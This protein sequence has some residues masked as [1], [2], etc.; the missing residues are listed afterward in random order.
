MKGAIALVLLLAACSDGG[1][2]PAPPTPTP[3][4]TPTPA[5]A[6][7]PAPV[8]PPPVGKTT[9]TVDGHSFVAELRPETG[10]FMASEPIFGDFVLTQPDDPKL[11]VQVAW[12]GEN[13]LGRPENINVTFVGPSGPLPVPDAGPAFG[14]QS[15][16]VTLGERDSVQRLYLSTWYS[17]ITPGAYTIKLAT[18][19]KAGIGKVMKDVDVAVEVPVEVVADD[20][21][22]L[23]A[24]I[25][26]QGAVVRGTDFDKAREALQ[27][28]RRIRDARVIDPLVAATKLPDYT[29]RYEALDCLE[30]WDDDRALAAIIAVGKTVA[31][32]LPAEGYTT[33]ALR[34]ES[35]AQL[36]VAAVGSLG[37]SKRPAAL[38]AVIAMKDDP[39]A[40]VRLEVLQRVAQLPD[41][42][43]LALLEGFAK[44]KSDPVRNEAK[45]Y[46]KERGHASP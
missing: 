2:R 14:G 17:A 31:A 42:T 46:L 1:K 40:D 33:A 6:P 16:S 28:L 26:R 36:R 21:A 22:A 43:G 35:A 23:G 29:L 19:I 11:A 9:I 32:D 44:D 7:A 25:E 8:G 30:A 37:R 5:P 41:P 12:M 45:R 27:R 10:R 24:L 20:A 13:T 39:S 3:T 38:D 4:P 34:E 15:W 18:R